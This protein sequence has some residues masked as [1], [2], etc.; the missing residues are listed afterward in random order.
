ME[1]DPASGD[2]IETVWRDPATPT[3]AQ[4]ADAAVKLHAEGLADTEL[5]QELYGLTDGQRHAMRQR[6]GGQPQ[7]PRA[8]IDRVRQAEVISA[9][10]NAGS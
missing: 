7:D 3:Q 1:R 4:K 6:A 8:I 5:A 10:A 9:S 2:R